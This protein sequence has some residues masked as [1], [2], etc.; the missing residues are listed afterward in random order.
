MMRRSRTYNYCEYFRGIRRSAVII[1]LQRQK[2]LAAADLETFARWKSYDKTVSS[3]GHGALLYSVE[4]ARSMN[5][6]MFHL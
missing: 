5:I 1:R 6:N 3:T 2:I 4:K